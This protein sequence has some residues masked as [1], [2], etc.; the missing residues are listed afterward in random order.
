M[1]F[2][3]SLIVRGND[4]TPETF[5]QVAQRAET[6]ELDALWLSAHVIIPP[7][8]KS[9][10]VMIPGL[11]HPPHWHERYWEPFTI[12]GY[13]AAVTSR[14]RLGTSVLVLPQHNPFEVAKQVA[15][16]DQLSNGR[17]DF[18]VGAGWFEEEFEVLGQSFANRGPRL[19]EALELIDAL[20]KPDPVTYEGQFY[21]VKDAYFGPKP[22]QSGNPPIW[23][24]GGSK[25]AMR[26]AARFADVF[27]PVRLLPEAIP[28]I[29]RT[30]GD[31]CEEYGRARDAV[32]IGVKVQLEFTGQP[33]AEGQ[34]PTQGRAQDIVDAIRRYQD[35]GVEHLVFDVA[36]EKREVLLDTIERFADEVRPHF[37]KST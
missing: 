33:T 12:L 24:A 35:A 23:I 7:Q 16:I 9:G 25:T 30:L 21:Q 2:G 15:E 3:F 18:G 20:W 27:H 22:V 37:T 4:A 13:L 5:R 14:I 10:Y 6:R 32:K 34:F 11:K 36:P 1:K 31:L 19:T 29:T 26:R 8:T 28:E 17:R